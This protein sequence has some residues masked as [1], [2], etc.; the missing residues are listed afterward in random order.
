MS[1]YTRV[2]SAAM[3]AGIESLSKANR[4]L[5][6]VLEDLKSQLAAHLQD[7]AGSAREEYRNV[8]NR[9]DNQAVEMNNVVAEMT[10]VLGQISQGYD[11]N[12]RRVAGRW[13][14]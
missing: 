5:Q 2:S 1:D 13:G 11:D 6:S 8:Q 3:T 4:D 9:W 10:K 14:A 7:W 12:E